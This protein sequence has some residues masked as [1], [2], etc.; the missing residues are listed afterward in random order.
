MMALRFIYFNSSEPQNA[1]S[2]KR[3]DLKTQN[4]PGGQ[5]SK[6]QLL[7]SD[8]LLIERFP[9]SMLGVRRSMFDV[10]SFLF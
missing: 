9:Y 10:H 8:F 4:P 1:E 7:C 2:R 3:R 5:V 6:G